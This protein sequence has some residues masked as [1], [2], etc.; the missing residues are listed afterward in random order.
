MDEVASIAPRMALDVAARAGMDVAALL[1]GLPF[2]REGLQ[3]RKRIDWDHYC[4][5]C[6]R[7][8]TAAGG[9]D[10]LFTLLQRS[11]H[12]AM[13]PAGQ[14][15]L[16]RLVSPRLLYRIMNMTGSNSWADVLDW[17]HVDLADDRLQ[18]TVRIR[19]PYTASA[20]FLRGSVAALTGVMGY[21]GLPPTRADIVELTERNLVVVLQLPPSTRLRDIVNEWRGLGASLREFTRAAFGSPA[22]SSFDDEA[23]DPVEERL[24]Q[25]VTIEPL[26]D[27]VMTIAGELG[28]SRAVLHLAPAEGGR[29]VV[30]RSR[31]DANI[32]ITEVLELRAPWRLVGV[33]EAGGDGS[34][35]RLRAL[36]PRI[37]ICLEAARILSVCEQ[38]TDAGKLA[39]LRP[40]ERQV[41]TC[42]LR[43][44][45]EKDVASTLAISQNTAHHHIKA[46]YRAFSVR[47]RNELLA[48]FVKLPPD[49]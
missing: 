18:V 3:R 21:I 46:V 33:L 47:S 48:I 31:G 19:P 14:A 7:M 22:D 44:Q 15:V 9:P 36:A 43:G 13:P 8:E 23:A 12:E 40:R 2:D 45:S 49:A 42:L 26:A 37:T 24:R 34:S 25:H 16:R 30:F 17:N 41:L 28:W 1:E 27:A 32:P 39:R 35:A 5:I 29:S 20:P 38:M 6:A 4:V 10:A 11:Y